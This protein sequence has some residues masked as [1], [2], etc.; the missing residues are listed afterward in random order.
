MLDKKIPKARLLTMREVLG[1]DSPEELVYIM[2]SAVE[3]ELKCLEALSDETA[4]KLSIFKKRGILCES[5]LAPGY[6]E[7]KNVFT[8]AGNLISY[9]SGYRIK[10]DYQDLNTIRHLYLDSNGNFT[11]DDG[12]FTSNIRVAFKWSEISEYCSNYHIAEDGVLEAEY[13]LWPCANK[14]PWLTAPIL[15]EIYNYQRKIAPYN[16]IEKGSVE[17]RL[18]LLNLT[19]LQYTT[20]HKSYEE[21]AECT[22]NPVYELDGMYFARIDDNING[23]SGNYKWTPLQPLKLWIDEEQ[24]VAVTACVICRV[25][26][27]E[28][29]EAYLENF[30]SQEVFAGF[31][32]TKQKE[33]CTEFEEKPM[34]PGIEITAPPKVG[35]QGTYLNL[36]SSSLQEEKITYPG[37]KED[38]QSEDEKPMFPGILI[39]EIDKTSPEEILQMG[40][41]KDEEKR[42]LKDE[43]NKQARVV[44][45][46]VKIKEEPSKF[47]TNLK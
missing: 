12:V 29:T 32:L 4:D 44:R 20:D 21:G 16:A 6:K 45:V 23:I 5:G 1:I 8:K 2:P 10:N 31:M 41:A 30:F 3:D 7:R 9:P 13:G 14:Y 34:F 37:L 42:R 18:Q 22:V 11:L 35:I 43:N 36:N 19:S 38:S 33:K 26:N 17:E 46:K 15:E 39:K 28:D 47:K 25:P 40:L 27:Y 24:D